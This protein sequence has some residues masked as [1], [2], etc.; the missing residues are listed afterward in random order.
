MCKPGF[1]GGR[2]GT[3]EGQ[4]QLIRWTAFSVVVTVEMITSTLR[5]KQSRMHST[6]G[7]ALA[8]SRLLP[9]CVKQFEA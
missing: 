4:A 8:K 6:A 7:R 1:E 3:W 2:K 5:I 9:I